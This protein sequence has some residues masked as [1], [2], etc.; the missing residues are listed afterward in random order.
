MLSHTEIVVRYQETDQMG[1]VHHSVYPI[2]F[3]CGR[4]D[5][6]Q[7]AG[8]TY[9]QMEK[10]GIMLP[11]LSLKCRYMSPC[12]YGD[13]VIVKTG[14]K[15]MKPARITFCYEVFRKGCVKPAASGETEHACANR[16]LKP[17][18]MKKYRPDLYQLL[19]NVFMQGENCEYE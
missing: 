13:T 12:F 10:D 17:V 18:N 19:I 11:L 16:Q 5:L 2:W 9:D 1:V 8:I 7:K 14:V 3:E 4:T 6:I 15:N